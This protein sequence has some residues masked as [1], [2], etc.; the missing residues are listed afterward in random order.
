[1]STS[2]LRYSYPMSQSVSTDAMNVC[3]HVFSV[4]VEEYFHVS[5]LEHTVVREQWESLPSRV[6]ES[7]ER[8]LELLATR[9][10]HGTFFI[11]GWV[12]K[13]NADL[14]RAIYRGGHEVASHG[15]LHRRVTHQSPNEFRK[16]VLDSKC[17]LEDLIG[18]P[19]KGYRAPSFSIVRET[20]W[21][22]EILAESGYAY[23]SSRFPIRRRGYG[24]PHVP[25]EPHVLSLKH[26][27]LL[28]IPLTVARLGSTKLPV[29]GGGWFRQFPA[30]VSEWAMHQRERENLPGI[31]YIHPW[32]LDPKQPRLAR[33]PLTYL[34]HY[35]GLGSVEQ[36]IKSMLKR[37]RFSSIERV[38]ASVMQDLVRTQV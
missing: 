14:V 27:R 9:E 23:D 37:F 7:T 32:E 34:R 16:D 13:R 22:L 31:F 1:M 4:D 8:L 6:L 2:D 28:E 3:T 5:A 10:Q 38:Y 35:R 24:S 20:E 11:L 18:A 19:V 25:I 26:G 15:F 12:A 29:A 33:S 17:L 30:C 36:K 21:A